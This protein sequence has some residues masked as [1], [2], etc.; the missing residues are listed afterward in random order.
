MGDM[1]KPNKKDKLAI[2]SYLKR[3]HRTSTST[4]DD[5]RIK[6]ITNDLKYQKQ[7]AGIYTVHLQEFAAD[8]IVRGDM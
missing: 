1:R 2:K 7:F 3:N 8:F 4:R 5:V 6:Y